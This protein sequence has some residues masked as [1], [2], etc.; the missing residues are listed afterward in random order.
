MHLLL[1][2]G[3]PLDL[4]PQLQAQVHHF[5]VDELT[6]STDPQRA[7]LRLV[8]GLARLAAPQAPLRAASGLQPLRSA[9]ASAGFE[10][11]PGAPDTCAVYQPRFTPRRRSRGAPPHA[12]RHALIV[13]AGLAGCATAWAL[14]EQGWRSTLI[15]RAAAPATAASGNP[16]GLFHGIVNPQ[17]GAHARFNRA[18]A[19]LAQRTVQ[20]AINSGTVRGNAQ[21]LLR[22]DLRGL[23]VDA[24]LTNWRRCNCR[25]TTYKRSM[26]GRPASAAACRWGTRP[27]STPAAAGCNRRRWRAGSCSRRAFRPTSAVA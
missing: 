17:D 14:A 15:D 12:E 19:L 7:A 24:M 8:K 1:G 23:G 26:R 3:E 13:G 11:E 21:G 5:L 4:L 10:V 18:A 9:L 6:L 16:A 22:L 2:V 25:P 20:R 27:G